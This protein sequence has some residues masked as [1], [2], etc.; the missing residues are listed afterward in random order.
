MRRPGDAVRP[1]TEL[2]LHPNGRKH[3][4]VS[5]VALA[6][7]SHRIWCLACGWEFHPCLLQALKVQYEALKTLSSNPQ[8]LSHTPLCL[9]CG[10]KFHSCCLQALKVQYEALKALSS[11]NQ[12]QLQSTRAQLHHAE[13][14]SLQAQ[15]LALQAGSTAREQQQKAQA[16]EQD[17]G[18]L[19]SVPSTNQTIIP[20]SIQD[21][22]PVK[23][24]PGH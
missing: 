8:T 10:W 11:N 13:A 6:F 22:A 18:R 9:T 3:R 20:M 15:Q 21:Q 12:A 1:S 7:M 14:A 24:P 2:Q 5:L 16:S 17:C 23:Y 19:R 4:S